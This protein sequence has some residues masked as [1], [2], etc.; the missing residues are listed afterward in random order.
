MSIINHLFVS[1]RE[2]QIEIKHWKIDRIFYFL[3]KVMVFGK[4]N[5]YKV[6]PISPIFDYFFQYF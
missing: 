2:L 4:T 6:Y 5:C 3:V 1:S